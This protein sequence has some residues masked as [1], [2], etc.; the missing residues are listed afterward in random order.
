MDAFRVDGQ[1]VIADFERERG[2][3]RWDTP[4]VIV[5]DRTVTRVFPTGAR[6][7]LTHNIVRVQAKDAID[8][9]GEL[10]IPSDADVLTLRTI[11]ADGSTRE[12]EE[13]GGDKES[14]SVPDLEPG[15]YVEYEYIDPAP[16]P[17]AFP[18][19]FLAE[20]F[21]FASYDAPL[22]RSE[23]VVA[24]PPE[25]KLQVDSRGK[26]VPAPE[27]SPG[28]DGLLLWTFRARAAAQRFTEPSQA[29][30]EEFL[31]SVRVGAN[32]SFAG[33][34]DFLT[35]AN[36]LTTRANGELLRVA[37]E[38]TRGARSDADKVRALD[39]W[40][41][42]H[43]KQGGSL[44]EAATSILAR[45]EGSRAT[46]L[47]ALL[48]AAGV[49]TELWLAHPPRA[50]EL[51]GELPDLEGYDEPYLVAAGMQLDPRFRHGAAGFLAPGLRGGRAFALGVGPVRLGK[52]GDA[53][54][55][56]RRM[57]FDVKLG[58]D[59]SAEVSVRERLVG[60][61]AIEWREAL[62]KLA[63]DRINAEFEQRTL[64][65]HFPGA[66]LVGL[67]FENRDDDAAPFIVAYKFRAPQLARRV[68][69]D[70]VVSAPF[71]AQLGKRYVG[72]GSR[73]TPMLIDY[74]PPTQV[75]AR[76]ALPE[77]TVAALPAPVRAA[78]PFGTFEQS[79]AGDASSVQLDARFTMSEARLSPA[80]YGE[81]VEFAQ[82]VDRAEARALE[83]RPAK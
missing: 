71:A 29:P 40:V 52:V 69:K 24:V 61:P 60:W 12:P 50:A 3:L 47:S 16:P 65:F 73:T 13:L 36:W 18:Q 46:L 10:T 17:A 15:D 23:Y 56:D 79:V 83:I 35:D 30:F 41:R 44:D 34:K 4:A 63:A 7:T 32:L 33:W 70:L 2:K 9:F 54:P 72:M 80:Q 19:G 8:K 31:P 55:D 25:M 11:K 75:H 77:R 6:L 27:R 39:A 82:R 21:Y 45:E 62:E 43:I 66:S 81:L 22:Y 38:V 57:D 28:G 37:A 51:D 5:L 53:N 74:T 42:K 48:R 64:G 1:K 78:A 67:G 49:R 58:A 20:R 68:G 59:G 76:I 26:S 14:I